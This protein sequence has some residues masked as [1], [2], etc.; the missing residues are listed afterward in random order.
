MSGCRRKTMARTDTIAQASL[1]HLGEMSKRL[2]QTFLREGSDQLSFE[3]ASVSLRRGESRLS[4]NVQRSLLYVSSSRLDEGSLPEQSPSRL[5]EALHPRRRVGR[6]CVLVWCFS[7]S[8]M[9][10]LHL[11]WLSYDG[12][13]GRNMHVWEGVWVMNDEL[14]WLLACDEHGMVGYKSGMIMRW[15]EILHTW[16]EYE[17]L[18]WVWPGTWKE[19]AIKVG[20]IYIHVWEML[21][22]CLNMFG[23]WSARNSLKALGEISGSCFSGRDVISWPLLV[24]VHG[25]A[26]SVWFGKDSR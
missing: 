25:G 10:G 5:S 16:M 14:E 1:S 11:I 21:L 6:E 17:E 2:A 18:E 24:G 19:L 4:D 26:P 15:I 8:W 23:L 7:Y 3:R 20:I 13:R 12:M 9:Y 22:G